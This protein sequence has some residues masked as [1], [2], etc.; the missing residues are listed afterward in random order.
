MTLP[1]LADIGKALPI[2]FR[3][4]P[5]VFDPCQQMD[6]NR[7]HL[8]S[9]ARTVCYMSVVEVTPQAQWMQSGLPKI[10]SKSHISEHEKV[11][12]TPEVPLKTVQNFCQKV[13]VATS[14]S[15]KKLPNWAPKSQL[16]QHCMQLCTQEILTNHGNFITGKSMMP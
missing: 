2:S 14:E 6:A 1:T 8:L 3:V 5:K 11:A 4:T 9:A 12:Q 15:L 16:W 7:M 10:I 13:T